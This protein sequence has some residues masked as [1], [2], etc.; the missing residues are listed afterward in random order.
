M[1]SPDAVLFPY[2]LCQQK[3]TNDNINYKVSEVL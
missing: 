3:T 1:T 2:L